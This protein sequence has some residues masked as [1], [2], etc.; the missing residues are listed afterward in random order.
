MTKRWLHIIFTALCFVAVCALCMNGQG[1]S[2]PQQ[3]PVPDDSSAT[4]STPRPMPLMGLQGEGLSILSIGNSSSV[5]PTQAHPFSIRAVRH[6]QQYRF[7]FLCSELQS[8]CSFPARVGSAY[9]VFALRRIL[10]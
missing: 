1:S 8:T 6:F 5:E 4:I 9:Y 10:C 2:G 3:P 7:I